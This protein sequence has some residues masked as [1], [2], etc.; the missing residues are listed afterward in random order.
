MLPYSD[1][2]ELSW[3]YGRGGVG[4]VEFR[5]R[6]TSRPFHPFLRCFWPVMEHP[7]TIR[8][9]LFLAVEF[10]AA[11]SHRRFSVDTVGSQKQG[12]SCFYCSP[13]PPPSSFPLL[14]FPDLPGPTAQCPEARCKQDREQIPPVEQAGCSPRRQ[15]RVHQGSR[16]QASALAAV[17]LRSCPGRGHKW[18]DLT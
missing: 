13:P 16:A 5:L 8:A 6:L 15:V 1:P 2:C 11:P 18:P 3:L 9:C 10:S 17:G 12:R 7:C 14:P 4:V